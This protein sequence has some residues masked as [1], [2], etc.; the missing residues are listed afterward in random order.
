MIVNGQALLRA[1]PIK[2]MLDHKV[3]G[4]LVS[5]GLTEAGYDIRIRESV[6]LDRTCRVA[7]A[8][9]LDEFQMPED[10]VGVVHD[11]STLA[12]KWL[13]VQNTVIEPGWRGW[14]T[15]EL[16]YNGNGVLMIPAGSGIA[17]VL[18]SRLTEPAAYDGKYQDQEARPVEAR[19]G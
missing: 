15:L 7:L 18:F 17:Q 9:T 3:R 10:M 8:S 19:H 2:D 4:Q 14:L 11:K 1:A 16:V 12:R 5:H 13:S 6:M